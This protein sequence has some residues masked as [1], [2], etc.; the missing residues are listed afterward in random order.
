[1]KKI[2]TIIVIVL[3]LAVAWVWS[4]YNSLVKMDEAAKTQWSQVEVSYQRRFDLIPNLVESVKGIMK[5]EQTVFND[6][7][8]ARSK[9]AGAKDTNQKAEATSQV[10]SALSRL[11]VITENYP[12]LKSSEN[13]QS[14]MAELAGTENRI[15]VERMR[16]NEKVQEYNTSIKFFPKSLIAS[17]FRFTEKSYFTADKS[18]ATAPKVSL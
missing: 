7:A 11:L 10:E 8:Q 4:G 17:I 14:L 15:N 5:Q 18:A 12:Q 16:Y 9:Y 3:V 6:L 1:M 13:V 2:S